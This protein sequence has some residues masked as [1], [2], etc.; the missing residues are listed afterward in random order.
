VRYGIRDVPDLLRTPVGRTSLL[1]GGLQLA[2]PTLARLASA[3]RRSL[4]RRTR[5]VAVVG[6]LGKTT[7]ARAVST[8]LG[9]DPHPRI[10]LNAV[11]PLALHVLRVRPGQPHAVI[12]VGIGAPGQMERYARLLRPDLVVVTSVT[13]AHGRMLPTLEITRREKGAMVRALA[14]G[15]T[16]ILNGD[17]ARVRSMAG[18]VR[19]RVVTYGLDP[20]NDVT[21]GDIHVEWP[22]GMRFV[23]RAGT[24]MLPLRTRLMGRPGVLA[25]L[26]AVAVV[27]AEERPLAP[28]LARLATLAPTRGRLEPLSLPNGATILRNDAGGEP[29]AVEAALELLAEIPAARRLVVL[30]EMSAEGRQIGPVRRAIAARIGAM[31]SRLILV[32]E[33]RDHGRG[34]KLAAQR[35]GLS[36]EHVERAGPRLGPIIERLGADLRPGDVVLITGRTTQR[37]ERIALALAGHTVRCD[38]IKCD[39][40]WTRCD[41][42]AMLARG[43]EGLRPLV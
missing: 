11:G 41:E 39:A 5:L 24:A 9:T 12:E 42:C 38:L 40:R 19:G 35:G 26:A 25:A 34:Y 6:S 1:A 2:W 21:A 36:V 3:Y 30:G 29:E 4:I 14:P 43:W 18:E 33:M 31:A 13:K 22:H 8:A 37:L 10:H 23:V 7:T 28:A 20:T 17:D 27:H 15:G 16:A 32:M